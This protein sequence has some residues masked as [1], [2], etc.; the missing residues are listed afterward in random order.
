MS[1]GRS[2]KVYLAGGTPGGLLTAEIG[3]WTGHVVA[4]PRSDLAGLLR[5]E[6]ARRTGV[7]LLIGEGSDNAARPRVYVGESDDVSSRLRYHAQDERKD[8]WERAIVLTSKDANL[9]KAHVRYLE[10]RFIAL[11]H[12]AGRASIENGSQPPPPPLPEADVSDMEYFVEQARIILPV[13]G[14][15]V[16]RSVARWSDP[17]A[18]EPVTP[19]APPPDV[20]PVFEFGLRSGGIAARA[21]EI[22]GEFTVLEGSTARAGWS[23]NPGGYEQVHERLRLDGS[24]ASTDDDQ[25]LVFTRSTVFT[26]VSAAAATVVGREENG[27]R[28][29]RV[30]GTNQT[31]ADWQNRGLDDAIEQR[32]RPVGLA[33]TTPSTG[34]SSPTFELRVDGE[35]IVARAQVVDGGF[36]VLGGSTARIGRVGVRP[37]YEDQRAA[38]RSDGTLVPAPDGSALVFVRPHRFRSVSAAASVVLARSANGRTEWKVEGTGI[39]FGQWQERATA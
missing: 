6:E 34:A 17:P 19:D 10:S 16:F 33:R 38:L 28:G 18:S 32:D 9:T 12:Q 25:V 22:D 35:G 21:Q 5:R 29:W 13:L 1:V 14:V 3:N 23:G 36:T 37:D 27:R 8:F 2:I 26:S 7:Y 30:A 31:Y 39:G 24:L 15:N 4:A 11:A 20:S